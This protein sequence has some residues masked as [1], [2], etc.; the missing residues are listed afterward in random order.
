MKYAKDFRKIARD[1]LYGKWKIAAL[2]C[3]VAILLGGAEAGR[4]NIELE[5]E[6]TWAQAVVEF[7]GVTIGPFGGRPDSHIGA[8]IIEHE[9]EILFSAMSIAIFQLIMGSIVEIG[10]TRFHLNLLDGKKAVFMDLF[11]YFFIWKKA[12]AA[13]FLRVL[14]VVLW[15]FV[16][17]IPGIIASFNYRMTSYIMAEHPE[18]SANEAIKRSKEL[19]KGN[20]WRLFCLDLSFIGWQILS[21]FTLGIG[22][23]WLIPYKKTAITAFYREISDTWEPLVDFE[24]ENNKE[25]RA[26][27]IGVAVVILILIVFCGSLLF[28]G[29]QHEQQKISQGESMMEQIL[30]YYED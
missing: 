10:H 20:R 5:I 17:I 11:R 30:Q 28:D 8:F 3:F 12:I 6:N 22:Q 9:K 1:T 27:I 25:H 16:F 13:K 4:L 24:Y 21:V 15:S 7:A 14:Y 2:V 23:L 29:K 19:M 18:L 26:G